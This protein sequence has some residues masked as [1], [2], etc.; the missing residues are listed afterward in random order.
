M[1]QLRTNVKSERSSPEHG[2]MRKQRAERK[3]KKE[4]VERMDRASG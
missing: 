2:E 3:G 1:R 4:E